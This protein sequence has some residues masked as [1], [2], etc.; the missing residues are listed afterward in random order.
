MTVCVPK[1]KTLL[2]AHARLSGKVLQS[3][4]ATCSSSKRFMN[5]KPMADR[6]RVKSVNAQVELMVSWFK[7]LS[8]RG[9]CWSIENPSNS[10]IWACPGFRGP[11]CAPAPESRTYCDGLTRVTK[12]PREH[13]TSRQPTCLSYGQLKYSP[14]L[15]RLQ[16]AIP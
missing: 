16:G 5:F 6:V 11:R 10:L 15:R 1:T 9:V 3:L 2:V 8:K 12:A 13:Q 4:C 7:S 14:G